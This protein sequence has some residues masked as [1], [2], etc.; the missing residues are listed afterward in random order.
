MYG[1]FF[2]KIS[3]L[4]SF[5]EQASDVAFLLADK[6]TEEQKSMAERDFYKLLYKNKSQE[7]N[8]FDPKKGA[9]L[10]TYDKRGE[11]SS[12]KQLKT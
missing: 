9:A 3:I 10:L 6:F 12:Y 7:I 4:E 11:I 1:L 5:D 8:V 2:L